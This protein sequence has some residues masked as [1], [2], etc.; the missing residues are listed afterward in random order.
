M[1]NRLVRVRSTPGYGG[2][3]GLGDVDLGLGVGFA[4]NG[5][6]QTGTNLRQ[7]ACVAAAYACA[8]RVVDGTSRG[9]ADAVARSKL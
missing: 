1:T 4:M 2:A 6:E 7:T 8:E 9:H 5:L 3:V